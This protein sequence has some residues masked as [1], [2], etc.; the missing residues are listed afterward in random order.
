MQQKLLR[1]MRTPYNN[2]IY[3]LNLQVTMDRLCPLNVS[4]NVNSAVVN[5]FKFQRSPITLVCVAT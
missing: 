2:N 5:G 4:S 1:R 3:Q